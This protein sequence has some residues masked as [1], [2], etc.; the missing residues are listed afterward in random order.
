MKHIYFFCIVIFIFI[1]HYCFAI[2]DKTYQRY[3]KNS[4]SF[5]ELETE[6]NSIWSDIIQLASEEEKKMLISQQK[7]WIFKKRDQEASKLREDTYILPVEAYELVTSARIFILKKYK[8]QLQSKNKKVSIEGRIYHGEI[9]N[10]KYW[11]LKANEVRYIL[12]SFEELKKYDQLLLKKNK[13]K[14]I[15][16]VEGKL[17]DLTSFDTT[18]VVLHTYTTVA[19]L[20]VVLF[21]IFFLFICF[22]VLCERLHKSKYPINDYE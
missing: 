1:P 18:T 17:K 9:D 14:V 8:E 21:S 19:F 22:C 13:E 5:N 7:K 12:G 6:L 2:D 4:E 10:K 11:I 16:K 20:K 15:I 3:K